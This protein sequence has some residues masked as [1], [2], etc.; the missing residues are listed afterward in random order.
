M[1]KR[2]ALAGVVQR[3]ERGACEPKGHQ[4][5][6]VRAHACVVGQVPSRGR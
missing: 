6:S 3:T 4:F 2:T 1:K 5:D